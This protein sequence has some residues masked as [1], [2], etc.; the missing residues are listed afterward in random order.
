[1][2]RWADLSV[3]N[4]RSYLAGAAGVASA[5]GCLGGETGAE[6]SMTDDEHL[7]E[8]RAEIDE[9]GVEYGAVE[10]EEAVVAVEHGYDDDPNDAIAEV[11][12][13]FVERIV[14]GWAV[15]R[16]AGRLRDGGTDWAWHAEAEWAREYADGEIGPEEYGSRLSETMEMRPDSER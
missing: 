2:C 16:L 6:S 10:L 4:R 7:A 9:R 13:A 12:M 1:M 8:L 5:A 14:D 3:M 11:A 15:D